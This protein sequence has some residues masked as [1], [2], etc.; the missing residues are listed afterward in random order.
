VNR[1]YHF[2]V[3]KH[4][5]SA[6][7]QHRHHADGVD[8]VLAWAETVG[9]FAI[10]MVTAIVSAN[11]I[12]EQGFRSARGL[13]RIGERFGAE[14]T[15]AAC[16][17]VVGFGARSYKPVERI[18]RLG[19]E[20]TTDRRAANNDSPGICHENVRGPLTDPTREKLA[21]LRLTAMADVWEQQ[22]RDARSSALALRFVRVHAFD[23]A[24]V[25]L[26]G[27]RRSRPVRYG[28]P[29]RARPP[30]RAPGRRSPARRRRSRPA[31]STAHRRWR[32]LPGS[33]ARAPLCN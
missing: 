21:V 2:E 18:L 28:A 26:T 16:E 15:E 22:R 31:T 11:V 29:W 24:H 27:C 9:P 7:Q 30:G 13:Q 4:L 33:R 17:P 6:P 5:Y 8:S 19:R 32:T 3:R 20:L 14:R 10:A 25:R 23:H 1:D 12:R